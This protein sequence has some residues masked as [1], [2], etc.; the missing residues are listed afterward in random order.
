MTSGRHHQGGKDTTMT[1]KDWLLRPLGGPALAAASGLLLAACGS[2]PP[3]PPPAP[4]PAPVSAQSEIEAALGQVA[5]RAARQGVE[6]LGVKAESTQ[7]VLALYYSGPPND[8]I[9]CETADWI[10]PA[11]EL[12]AVDLGRDG[13]FETLVGADPVTVER[14]VRLDAMTKIEAKPAYGR[15]A[16][17]PRS[18]YILSGVIETYDRSRRLVGRQAERVE[19]DG[20]Q[21]AK[22]SSGHTCRATGTLEKQLTGAP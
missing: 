13:T 22:L 9:Q 19:F 2:A 8:V 20:D 1:M 17:Q 6:V 18:H 16:L 11:G 21:V 14:R 15:I 12:R 10:S 5:L 4:P 3:P 7:G